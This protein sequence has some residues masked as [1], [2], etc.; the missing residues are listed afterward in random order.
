MESKSFFFFSVAQVV[1]A[2]RFSFKLWLIGEDLR[3]PNFWDHWFLGWG[4]RFQ[5]FW[6]SS[7]ILRYV[8]GIIF[9]S[10]VDWGGWVMR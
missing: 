3:G 7:I 9:P 2:K 6:D 1:S 10:C 8:Q 5:T 4:F